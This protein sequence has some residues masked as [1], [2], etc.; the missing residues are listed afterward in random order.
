VLHRF[1]AE[2]IEQSESGL[3]EPQ[4]PRSGLAGRVP[5]HLKGMKVTRRL[6]QPIAPIAYRFVSFA[7]QLGN[8]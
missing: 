8:R 3:V 1:L 7:R 4:Q 5:M 6:D 2:L